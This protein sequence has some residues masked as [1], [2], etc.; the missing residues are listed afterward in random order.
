MGFLHFLRGV[1]AIDVVGLREGHD[2]D[3]KNYRQT[4]MLLA[5][6]PTSRA[7]ITSVAARTASAA[8]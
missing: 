5:G 4:K 8:R 6:T 1:S 2:D 7:S 3:A